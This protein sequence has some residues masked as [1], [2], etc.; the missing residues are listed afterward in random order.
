MIIIGMFLL[1]Y[2]L[3]ALV[4]PLNLKLATPFHYLLNPDI[5]SKYA[6]TTASISIRALAI[7]LTPL[8]VM[9]FWNNNSTAKGAI[10]LVAVPLMELYALQDIATRAQVVPLE[11]SLSISLGGLALLLPMVL[12]FIR[13]AFSGKG[14][15][16]DQ[17]TMSELLQ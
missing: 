8:L 17:Q 10:L 15:T 9:S 12:Y 13:G 14:S 7:F 11:W 3:D 16:N 2:L 4:P 5:L 1:S 6:F